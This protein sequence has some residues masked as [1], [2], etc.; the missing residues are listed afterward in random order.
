LRDPKPAKTA[1]KEMV[2]KKPVL[3]AC[4]T[5]I[6]TSTHVADRLQR[7]FASRGIDATITQCRVVEI[8]AYVDDV[9]VIVATAVVP[10][11]AY[12]VPVVSGIPFLTGI[13]DRL[14]DPYLRE[15]AADVREVG[16]LLAA[17]LAGARPEDLP[18]SL[19]P[20]SSSRTKCRRPTPSASTAP[21]SSPS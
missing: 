16:W 15:R 1:L 3:V 5:A 17:G 12:R 10:Q 8:G 6:A 21:T 7:E 20:L 14:A 2:R 9:D 19:R 11:A 4:G 13:G 18:R